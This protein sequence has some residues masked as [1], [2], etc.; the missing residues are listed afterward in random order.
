LA[1]HHGNWLLI[2]EIEVLR[3]AFVEVRTKHP[4]RIDAVV[5]LLV[6]F[7]CIWTLPVG[8]ADFSTRWS[9]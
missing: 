4:F 5:V 3:A 9:A 7:H 8:D 6:H 2:D 1:E